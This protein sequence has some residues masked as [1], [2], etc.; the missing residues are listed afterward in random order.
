[1][2]VNLFAGMRVNL[3]EVAGTEVEI[4]RDELPWTAR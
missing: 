3:G 4:A 1:V 2:Y